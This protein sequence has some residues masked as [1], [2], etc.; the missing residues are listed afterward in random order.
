VVF[1][2]FNAPAQSAKIAPFDKIVKDVITCILCLSCR[3]KLRVPRR[4]SSV[5]EF[6]RIGIRFAVSLYSFGGMKR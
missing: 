4:R 1:I 6:S 3:L 5:S 2:F